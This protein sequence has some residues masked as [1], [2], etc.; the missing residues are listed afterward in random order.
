MHLICLIKEH[1]IQ[2]NSRRKEDFKCCY[3]IDLIELLHIGLIAVRIR[4]TNF[5]LYQLCGGYDEIILDNRHK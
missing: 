1:Y 3:N 2:V 4:V 5:S